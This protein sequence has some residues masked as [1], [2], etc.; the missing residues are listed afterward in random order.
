MDS[1][2]VTSV[3]TVDTDCFLD[4]P[5]ST[6]LLYFHMIA[7]ADSNG[8]INNPKGILRICNCTDVDLSI[9]MDKGYLIKFEFGVKISNCWS[10][11]SKLGL[12]NSKMKK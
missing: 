3:E 1:S 9:L 5:A 11:I 4:M 2:F 8:F 6:Q 7:R 12:Y 10:N